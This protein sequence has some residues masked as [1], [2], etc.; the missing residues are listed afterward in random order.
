MSG[1]RI[2]RPSGRYGAS[3]TSAGFRVFGRA[4]LLGA[5]TGLVTGAVAGEALT[6]GTEYAGAGLMVGGAVGIV[7]GT[8]LGACLGPLLARRSA[9]NG[10]HPRRAD[11]ILAAAGACGAALATCLSMVEWEP[12][13]AVVAAVVSMGVAGAAALWGLAWVMAPAGSARVAAPTS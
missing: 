7:L 5:G 11:R 12:T 13:R 2:V 10:G 9:A 4:V 6:L 1:D 8:V 3:E